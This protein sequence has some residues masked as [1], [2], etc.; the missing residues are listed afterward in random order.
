MRKFLTDQFDKPL[1]DASLAG[2]HQQVNAIAHVIDSSPIGPLPK[3]K[4]KKW[5]QQMVYI[6]AYK[7]LNQ[8]GKDIT[9]GRLP[10]LLV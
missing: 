1:Y 10:D 6:A 4:V 7:A 3:N 2:L 9:D 8:F 5:A